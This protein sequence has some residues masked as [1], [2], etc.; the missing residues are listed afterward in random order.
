VIILDTDHVVVLKYEGSPQAEALSANM[1]ASFERDFAI[2]AVT[3]EEQMRGWLALIHRS[4][5]VHRRLPAYERLAELFDFFSRWNIV[6]FDK[7]A[8]DEF[9]R[10]RK[11]KTRI[12]TMD[13]K[14]AATALVQ[15]A[16]VLS[17]NRRDF[18]QVPGL[19][20]ENWLR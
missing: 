19:R 14:I 5:D 3:I 7:A 8:A 9:V 17:A 11:Q 13:L 10:L 2:T 15:D 4:P 16:L 6:P 20:V 18:E 12:G 1:A